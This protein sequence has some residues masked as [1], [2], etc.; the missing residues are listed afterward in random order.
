MVVVRRGGQKFCVDKYEASVV[1]IRPDG[2]EAPHPHYLPVDGMTVRALSRRGVFPQGYISEV[3]AKEACENSRKRLCRYDEWKLACTSGGERRFPYGATREPGKCNDHGA[4]PVI[5]VFGA[6]AVAAAPVSRFGVAPSSKK[7][8]RK[9]ATS[10]KK[11][12]GKSPKGALPKQANLNGPDLNV[13]TQLNDPRLGQTENGLARTGDHEACE[14]EDGA[15]DMMG[16]LHEWVDNGESAPRGVFAGGYFLD[17]AKNGD[18][19][20]YATK[21]HARDYHDYST[22]FRCCSDVIE[23]EQPP[24]SLEGEKGR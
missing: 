15:V 7:G 5:A 12:A 1:E 19:C 21:A 4:S 8:A 9:D 23:A 2:T 13:W 14:T 16:N 3:Q 20:E 11:P 24:A 10:K 18:G 6:K 22:G 17:T